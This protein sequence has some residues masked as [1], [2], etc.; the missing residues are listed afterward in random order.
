M[1]SNTVQCEWTEVKKK[2]MLDKMLFNA[3]NIALNVSICLIMILSETI[4]ASA[5]PRST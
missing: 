1:V 2:S 5:P 4:L 3:C